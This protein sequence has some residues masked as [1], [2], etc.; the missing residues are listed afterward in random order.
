[1]SAKPPETLGLAR[2]LRLYAPQVSVADLV[3]ATGKTRTTVHR[4]WRTQPELMK[5]LISGI[6]QR[7]IWGG[8]AA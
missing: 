2:F 5:L 1:M 3:A 8:N 6:Q 4:W 7:K